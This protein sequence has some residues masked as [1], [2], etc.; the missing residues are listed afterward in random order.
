MTVLYLLLLINGNIVEYPTAKYANGGFG[1]SHC[2][3]Q[4]EQN[5]KLNIGTI[6]VC[7]G[8]PK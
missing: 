8:V 5:M 2:L 4:A 3:A 6:W 1:V 7:K